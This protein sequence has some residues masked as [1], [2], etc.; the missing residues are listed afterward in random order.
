MQA[1][2][3]PQKVVKHAACL[4]F[5]GDA[6]NV[7]SMYVYHAVLC[8]TDNDSHQYIHT[9]IVDGRTKSLPDSDAIRKRK[10]LRCFVIGSAHC[11]KTTMVHRFIASESIHK[12]VFRSDGKPLSKVIEGINFITDDY[13]DDPKLLVVC[14]T[15]ER[16]SE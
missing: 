10:V 5:R 14:T 15:S 11:G 13:I 1:L 2:N 8:T 9:R 16:L 12:A 3:E 6:R 7:L 4:G